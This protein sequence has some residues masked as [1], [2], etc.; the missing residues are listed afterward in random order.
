VVAPHRRLGEGGH[1]QFVR[2]TPVRFVVV[3]GEQAVAADD[4]QRDDL[5]AQVLAEPLLVVEVGDDLSA[6]GHHITRA[7]ERELEDRPQ[8]GR[9]VDRRAG[10]LV[11]AKSQDVA[12]Q[13]NPLGRARNPHIPQGLARSTPVGFGGNGDHGSSLRRCCTCVK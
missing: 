10:G 12:E 9:V 1:Q 13:R 6:G 11:A 4:P 5:R 7:H 3:G 8:L 2:T